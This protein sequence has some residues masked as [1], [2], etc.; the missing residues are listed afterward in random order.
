MTW[1]KNLL[2]K[3]VSAETAL[4]ATKDGDSVFLGVVCGVPY[5]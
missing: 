3:V 2:P 1:E 4:D 5:R